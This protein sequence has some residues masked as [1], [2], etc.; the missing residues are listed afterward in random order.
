[1]KAISLFLILMPLCLVTSS[2]VCASHDDFQASVTLSQRSILPYEPVGVWFLLKNVSQQTQS[3]KS[4]YEGTNF[5][6]I[7]PEKSEVWLPCIEKSG[8]PSP[9]S[10]KE[11]EPGAGISYYSH[12]TIDVT[13]SPIFTKPGI[14]KI[15]GVILDWTTDTQIVSESQQLEVRHPQNADAAAAAFV[16]A[17]ALYNLF[18]SENVESS[19]KPTGSDFNH[20]QFLIRK[21]PQ[22]RYAEWAK[23]GL[24]L[25]QEWQSHQGHNLSIAI[26]QEIAIQQKLERLAPGLSPPITAWCWYEAGR[27]AA[28]RA[29]EASGRSAQLDFASALATKAD[30][31]IATLIDGTTIIDAPQPLSKYQATI[32]A[33]ESQHYDVKN[34]IFTHPR[35]QSQFVRAVNGLVDQYNRHEISAEE[36]DGRRAALLDTM[37]RQ[38]SQPLSPEE[39]K[40]R[41]NK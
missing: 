1:M 37:I 25:L 4:S 34:F 20:L 41:P 27:I 2:R 33:L 5:V 11:F 10:I 29:D 23:I 39:W 8:L 26:Q 38:N 15:R 16:S 17:H 9:S 18:T 32:N 13:G 28:Q 24:L 14:Y 35:E 6:E 40:N 12:M 30:P 31:T 3:F 22:S 21:F 36:M 7:Q 19:N